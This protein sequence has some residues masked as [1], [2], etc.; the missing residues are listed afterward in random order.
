MPPRCTWRGQENA[1][2]AQDES[3][4]YVESED[5]PDRLL[6]DTKIVKDDGYQKQQ[7]GPFTILA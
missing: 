1:D 5:Q 6:L 2:K 3:K 4:I 7:G